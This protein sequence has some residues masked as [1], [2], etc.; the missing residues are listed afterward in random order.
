VVRANHLTVIFNFQGK[1]KC[2]NVRLI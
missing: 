2:L 1:M